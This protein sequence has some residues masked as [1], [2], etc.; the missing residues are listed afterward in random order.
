M[1]AYIQ[2]IQGINSGYSFPYPIFFEGARLL[3]LVIPV[4]IAIPVILT[5]L[6]AIGVYVTYM[7]YKE[8]ELNGILANIGCFSSFLVSMVFIS[9]IGPMD[10]EYGE[11]YLGVFS[12]NPYQNATYI[13]TR[14]FAILLMIKFIKILSE[15]PK[16][17]VKDCVL[18]GVYMILSTL[19]KPSYI[20]VIA[21]VFA[22]VFI[23]K[24]LKKKFRL[25][26]CDY[27]ILVGALITI[28]ILIWQY[29]MVFDVDAGGVKFGP[30]MAWHIWTP[31]I[32]TA[33]IKA[34]LFPFFFC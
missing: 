18:F 2:E 21:P 10:G 14:P 15:Y 4:Y 25:E 34:N 6:N 1:K 23:I 28:G 3:S 33:I 22:I 16:C 9:L 5:A 7:Y 17:S 13:A 30:G 12:P 32:K 24:W 20:F 31:S 29:I 19:A 26:K 11:R 27:I 8:Q